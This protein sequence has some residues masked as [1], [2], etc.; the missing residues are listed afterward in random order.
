LR[1]KTQAQ[2]CCCEAFQQEYASRG[3]GYR[4]D[5]ADY[6]YLFVVNGGY[7]MIKNWINK[8]EKER[9]ERIAELLLHT[10]EKVLE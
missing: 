1:R 5:E 3:G 6:I 2:W 8:E 4:N 7:A 9:P 10:A